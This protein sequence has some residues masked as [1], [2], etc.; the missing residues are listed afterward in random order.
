MNRAVWSVVCQSFFCTQRTR[1][2]HLQIPL[3]SANF[4]VIVFNLHISSLSLSLWFVTI[5]RLNHISVLSSIMLFRRWRSIINLSGWIDAGLL[6][7]RHNSLLQQFG[8][9]EEKKSF[10]D[11]P[12]CIHVK[13]ICP[14]IAPQLW[15]SFR[16]PCK[17]T[18]HKR[19]YLFAL[20]SL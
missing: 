8:Y 14:H 20:I 12:F 19:S 7:G 17:A 9:A 6:P 18:Q 10:S 5:F 1:V 16:S 3:I 11:K 13:N 2:C 15:L 4:C